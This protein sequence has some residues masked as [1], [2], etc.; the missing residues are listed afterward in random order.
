MQ[1]LRVLIAVPV[2]VLDEDVAIVL[3][4]DPCLIVV[5][6]SHFFQSI[7]RM[8]SC[9]NSMCS[10]WWSV[11]RPMESRN[12]RSQWRRQWKERKV[13][14][15]SHRRVHQWQLPH[16]SS[17]LFVG[18]AE[19][20]DCVIVTREAQWQIIANR[21]A[22]IIIVARWSAAVSNCGRVRDPS[23]HR[24]RKRNQGLRIAMVWCIVTALH[25][26]S[27]LARAVVD[28]APFHTLCM[29]HCRGAR[30]APG[31]SPGPRVKAFVH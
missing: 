26:S 14:A 1:F 28:Y 8:F 5:F 12:R 20:C 2:F 16:R 18:A 19:D 9:S 10:F 4:L 13:V 29:Q 27:Q 30:E 11:D 25:R 22:V 17:F 15:I 3:A 7:S 23:R 24:R 21:E 31:R 6:Y